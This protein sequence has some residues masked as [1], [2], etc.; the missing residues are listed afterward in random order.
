MAARR[1]R[2]QEPTGE[3]GRPGHWKAD[4]TPKTSFGSE[5]DANRAAFQARL[6]HGVDLTA[7]GCDF[8]P[9]WHLGTS[10]GD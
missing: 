2:R 6:D 7:Y 4:G 10:P 8:C 9:A 1:N 3:R 5:A